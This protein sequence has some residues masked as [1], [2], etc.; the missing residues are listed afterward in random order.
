LSLIFVD[1]SIF[2]MLSISR[3]EEFSP[4]F[5]HISLFKKEKSR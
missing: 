3:I 5:R 1:T 4:F 2:V